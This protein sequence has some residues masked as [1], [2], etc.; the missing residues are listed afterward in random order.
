MWNR[1]VLVLHPPA[2]LL[3]LAVVFVAPTAAMAQATEPADARS[4]SWWHALSCHVVELGR[5]G[6]LSVRLRVR[7][8]ASIADAEWLAFEFENDGTEPIVLEAPSYSIR[9]EQCHPQT[10]AVLLSGPMASGGA[11]DMFPQS[12]QESSVVPITIA[13]GLHR[14][15]EH[16][17][18]YS[19]ALLGLAPRDGCRVQARLH[20]ATGISGHGRLATPPEGVRFAFDWAHPGEQG[21]AVARERLTEL[22]AQPTTSVQRNYFASALLGIPEVGG[23]LS[24]EACLA[25]IDRQ[26]GPWNVRDT[27][28]SYLGSRSPTDPK[29]LAYYRQRLV[30][31]DERVLDELA[32][33]PRI[34]DESFVEPIVKM[35]EADPRRQGRALSV[36]HDHGRPQR[37]PAI[38]RR[39]STALLTT[40]PLA[41]S[42]L[43]QIWSFGARAMGLTGDV[44]MI[45]LLRPFLDKNARVIPMDCPGRA[46]PPDGS[47]L[48]PMRACDCALDAI[49]T[50]LDGDASI[51]YPPRA[52]WRWSTSLERHDAALLE[53]R[54][55]MI[56]GLKRRLDATAGTRR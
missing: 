8:T 54:D 23:V 51:A 13:P 38:A 39:L 7:R 46:I 27:L 6:D 2:S 11:F 30:P 25:A 28:V 1:R 26:V 50:L 22:L 56:R 55:E 33:A 53:I 18:L 31:T 36:L 16:P 34:W 24:A 20:F 5:G 44:A 9:G 45:A 12:W 37:A 32:R 21:F 15:A 35:Y 48:E 49:L 14:I 42:E 3:A 43:D 29:V 52:R 41:R 19:A 17:T 40:D 47:I 10:G 4:A